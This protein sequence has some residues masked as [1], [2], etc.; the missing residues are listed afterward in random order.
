M[1]E[2]SGDLISF[3][4][5]EGCGKSTQAK[6]AA[7]FLDEQDLKVLLSRE[8]GATAMGRELR[9]LLL[10]PDFA[11]ETMTELLLYLADRREH[12]R[13]IIQPHLERGFLVLVDRYIDSTWVYQGYARDGDLDLIDRMNELVTGGLCPRR[14]FLLDCPPEIGLQ[15]ARKRN[16]TDGSWGCEDRFEQLDMA[17]HQQIREGFLL[18]A[19]QHPERIVVLDATR[20]VENIHRQIR[21]VLEALYVVR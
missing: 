16:L 20:D 21:E 2:V 10:S 7:A 18:L 9:R 17:F 3:E 12:V 15:R 13:K 4:G 6:L 14:T 1:K 11:P 5:I 19:R 8:P